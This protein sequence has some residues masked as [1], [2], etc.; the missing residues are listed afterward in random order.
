M[1]PQP[2][3]RLSLGFVILA[4]LAGSASAQ[5]PDR[6][7]GAPAP[8]GGAVP[9][10]LVRAED[11]VDDHEHAVLGAFVLDQLAAGVHGEELAEAIH[12]KQ[13]ELKAE[14]ERAQER[15]R[16][17]EER[18]RRSDD[19][20]ERRKAAAEAGSV[21][22][23]KGSA[24]ENGPGTALRHGLEDKDLPGMGRFVNQ[25]LAAGLRGEEL[26]DSIRQELERRQAERAKERAERA[27]RAE[28]ARA[29]RAAAA[30]EAAQRRAQGGSGDDAAANAARQ[31]DRQGLDGD[32]ASDENRQGGGFSGESQ[33]SSHGNAGGNG[34]GGGYGG[35]FGGG[36]GGGHGHR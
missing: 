14:C 5:A 32:D 27:Q 28:Q 8:G 33:G 10:G 19:R 2:R 29:A 26:A 16:Q 4:V 1:L 21:D 3:R 23:G 35:G 7:P 17:A 12:R 15:R 13:A 34:A 22:P 25:Q 20:E 6:Q 36:H 30:A 9:P 24:P 31:H 18:R 11:R